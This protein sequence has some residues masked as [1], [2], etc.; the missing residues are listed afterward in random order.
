[1]GGNRFGV[2]GP[3]ILASTVYFNNVLGWALLHSRFHMTDRNAK[4]G[5]MN[6][7]PVVFTSTKYVKKSIPLEF[8]YVGINVFDPFAA[9]G[10]SLGVGILKSAEYSVFNYVLTVEV[11]YR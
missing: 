10:T 1:V 5:T 8:G 7:S 3:N 4:T 11:G 2:T 9:I 6:G